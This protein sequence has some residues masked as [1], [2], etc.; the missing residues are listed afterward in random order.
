MSEPNGPGWEFLEDVAIAD[1]AFLAYGEDLETLFH[2]AAEATTAVM[3]DDTAT[4]AA[5]ERREVALVEEDVEMLLFDFLQELIYYKDAE[6]LLLRPEHVEIREGESGY[7]L[8]AVLAG[9]HLDRERHPLNADVKA[10]TMHRFA[11]CRTD[12]GYEASVVLDI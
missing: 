12:D 7:R 1:V 5:R 3:V 6:E 10:V 2:N 9:E 11:V 8:A 4:V